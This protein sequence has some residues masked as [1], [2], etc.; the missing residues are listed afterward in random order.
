MEGVAVNQ[1]VN[2]DKARLYVGYMPCYAHG[3]RE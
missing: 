2:L 3:N 1:L